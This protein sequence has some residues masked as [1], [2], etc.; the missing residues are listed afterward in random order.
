MKSAQNIYQKSFGDF[1]TKIDE[2]NQQF[3]TPIDLGLFFFG[4]GGGEW[5]G[6]IFFWGGGGKKVWGGELKNFL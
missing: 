1:G 3:G 5:G 6:I 2:K 4:E